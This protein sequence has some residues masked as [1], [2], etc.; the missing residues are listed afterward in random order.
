MIRITDDESLLKALQEID[1]SSENINS[2]Q[3]LYEAILLQ[4]ENQ[5]YEEEEVN[6]MF[7]LLSQREEL[8][9]LIENLTL[10]ATGDLLK[11]LNELDIDKEKIHS[12]VDLISYLLEQADDHSY[13]EQDAMALLLNYLEEKDLGEVVAR[14][15]IA[16]STGDLQTLLINL[17]IEKNNLHN[18][19]DLYQ[20]LID[21]ADSHDYTVTDVMKLFLNLLEAIENQP[22][23]T[24]IEVPE[25]REEVRERTGGTWQFYVLGGL[26]LLIILFFIRRRKKSDGDKD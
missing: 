2:L 21:Q 25:P 7:S 19:S 12:P 11:V 20:Y 10:I 18:L 15:L 16:N 1:L 4:A 23:V 5:G 14:V 17:D 13:S 24:E 8:N 9:E 6:E 22:L 3:E 26:L